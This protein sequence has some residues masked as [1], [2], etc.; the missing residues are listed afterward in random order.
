MLHCFLQIVRGVLQ[1]QKNT[2]RYM[3]K[4]LLSPCALT[5][6]CL[7]PDYYWLCNSKKK[8]SKK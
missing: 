7:G 1:T 6:F 3:K 8:V 4:K 5:K 2:G